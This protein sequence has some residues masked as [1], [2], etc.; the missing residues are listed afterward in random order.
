M[1][2]AKLEGQLQTALAGHYRIESELGRGA[3]ARVFLARDLRHDRAVAV[4][5]LPPDLATPAMAERFL[6]EIR[7]TAALQHPN[8]LPLMDSGTSAGLCWYVMPFV[9]GESLRALLK[10][11][12]LPLLDASRFAVE[13]ARALSH[14]HSHGVVHRDIKPENIMVSGGHAIVM[15]FGLGRAL[16]GGATSTRLTAM[17]LPLGTPAYMS[18]EQIQG[19]DADERSDVYGL[20]CVLYEMVTGRPPFTGALSQV[21]RAQ[22]N[23]PPTPAS[24]LRP[25]L[26]QAID[27]A[28]DRALQKDPARRYPNADEF[29]TDLE[30]IAALAM[31]E[32]V[33]GEPKK[34]PAKSGFRKLLD[35]LGGG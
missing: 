19:G 7:I 17:G 13:V 9:Q 4:K 28:V 34:E 23:D 12:P 20:G 32:G 27:R 35:K 2:E 6:R 29:V 16:S 25:G 22:V 11:G 26:P 8:I 31:L 21:L 15:D 10:D 3:M 1:T 24:K 14:A 33:G 18:P 30:R 5:L